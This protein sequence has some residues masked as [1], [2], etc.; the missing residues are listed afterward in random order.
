[1]VFRPSFYRG[2]NMLTIKA[3][4]RI[5]LFGGGTDIPEY[6]Q[7]HGSVIISFAIDKSIYLIRNAR[8]TG[9][10]RISYSQVEE[11]DSPLDA[12]HTLVRAYAEK[13]GE[14]FPSTLS[15][16][17]DLPKGTGL[18]SS[19]ALSVCLCLCRWIGPL[20]TKLL[21]AEAFALE[22]S[23]SPVGIQD[24]LPAVYG[25]FNTYTIS[26]NGKVSVKPM[27][28]PAW[29]LIESHGLLLYTGI[30]REAN[31]ILEGLKTETDSLHYI[32]IL[33]GTM[34]I[35]AEQWTPEILGEALD[36]TWQEKQAIA[37][38]SNTVLNTQYL[39]A[40]VAG[41]IGGKLLGAGG[42]GCWFFIVPPSMRGD[43]KSA[44]GLAEIPFRISKSGVKE[45]RL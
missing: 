9:G 13:Y 30:S 32:S 6:Y 39:T 40:L 28:E 43:V 23:V 21:V 5:S 36:A 26:R 19:S 29:R 31:K 45:W 24:F 16:V 18:G 1:M 4:L 44:L 20:R 22:R 38:V 10:Y 2:Q 33:A 41:A 14:W 7:Q 15:I 8:P 12:Q 27:P 17:G 42:G 34:A 25:G 11:L 35:N 3:P 37:G